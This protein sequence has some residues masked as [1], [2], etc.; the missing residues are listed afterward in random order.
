MNSK[1][2][3]TLFINSSQ[4]RFR[5][6]RDDMM[7]KLND[8]HILNEAHEIENSPHSFWLMNPWFDETKDYIIDFLTK[9]FN[10]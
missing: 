1:T 10:K 3:P 7:K 4:P 2:P 8:Y 9:R 5:A 6:G